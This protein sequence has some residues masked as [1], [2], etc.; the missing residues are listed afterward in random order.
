MLG[1]PRAGRF[2]R[3]RDTCGERAMPL[4]RDLAGLRGNSKTAEYVTFRIEHRR[5]NSKDAG[6][7]FSDRDAVAGLAD[8]PE[9]YSECVP[10][11]GRAHV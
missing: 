7:E 4:H 11:I 2:G 9:R 3:A 1:D 10:E 5:G 8:R 6:P